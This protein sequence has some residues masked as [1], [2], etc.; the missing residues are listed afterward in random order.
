MAPFA[1]LLQPS[2]N[3]CFTFVKAKFLKHENL[4]FQRIDIKGMQ[5]GA[6]YKELRQTKFAGS[7]T[8][9]C[10]E[11]IILEQYI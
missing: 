1:M 5:I 6:C 4:L 3:L 9:V 7:V 10:A 2:I 11:S 8:P